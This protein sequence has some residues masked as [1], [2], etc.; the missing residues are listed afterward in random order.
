MLISQKNHSDLLSDHWSGKFV[1][2]LPLRSYISPNEEACLSKQTGIV[3]KHAQTCYVKLNVA[4]KFLKPTKPEV[5]RDFKISQKEQ[6]N[7]FYAQE[8]E[9]KR[10]FPK[11]KFKS[12]SQESYL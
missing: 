8:G 3:E 2:L 10:I 1:N 5:S 7:M 11:G 6:F 12:P 4:R 9:G